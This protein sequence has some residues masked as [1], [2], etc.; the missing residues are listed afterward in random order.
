MENNL[1]KQIIAAREFLKKGKVAEAETLAL[2]LQE[3]SPDVLELSILLGDIY[4]QKKDPDTAEDFY[5]KAL[6]LDSK[7]LWALMGLADICRLRGLYREAID[8]YSSALLI[9]PNLSWA[10]ICLG[11]A[12]VSLKEWDSAFANYLAADNLNDKPLLAK[13]GLGT[14]ALGMNDFASAQ[15]YFKLAIG[16]NKRHLNAHLGL[17]QSYIGA[18]QWQDAQAALEV[19]K[20]ISPDDESIEKI[21]REITRG[22]NRGRSA[23]IQ[24]A[25]DLAYQKG[26]FVQARELYQQLLELFP[27]AV[28]PLCRLATMALVDKNSDLAF[29]LFQQASLCQPSYPWG[30]VGLGDCHAALQRWSDAIECYENALQLKPNNEYIAGLIAAA[31]EQLALRLQALPDLIKR[32]DGEFSRRD[33]AAAEEAYCEALQISP[34][35]IHPLCRLGEIFLL[36]NEAASAL[37]YYRQAVAIDRNYVWAQVGLGQASVALGEFS[38]AKSALRHAL[39]LRADVAF[40][41]QEF[42]KAIAGELLQEAAKALGQGAFDEVY[43]EMAAALVYDP[44]SPLAYTLLQQLKARQ[45][46][47]GEGEFSEHELELEIHRIYLKGLEQH[48]QRFGCAIPPVA[49]EIS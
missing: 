29:N 49:Q 23:E 19:A 11:D 17:A 9:K 21:S 5:R 36:Q 35:L 44:E 7:A 34:G 37:D 14:A 22:I 13:L 6:K 45:A 30:H 48:L 3:A 31:K 26:D 10:H 2:E 32:A 28:H 16:V 39:S 12:F 33:F 20:Q 18:E 41:E 24:K 46:G 15:E 8:A 43:R 27:D 1:K 47:S 4:T 38:Q 25:A 42:K 40:I